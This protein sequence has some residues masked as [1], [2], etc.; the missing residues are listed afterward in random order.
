MDADQLAQATARPIPVDGALER[1][2]DGHPDAA[3]RSL[4]RDCKRDHGAAV[5]QPLSADRRLEVAVPAQPIAPFQGKAGLSA[6]PQAALASPVP[7]HAHATPRA[8]A[9]QEAVDAAAVTLLGL[10][11]SL[12][13][14]G[15]PCQLKVRAR[16]A[17]G[18]RDRGSVPDRGLAKPD[19]AGITS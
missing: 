11:G 13:G 9:A 8:H 5:E 14:F 10:E 3:L 7:D 19:T 17:E 16:H 18:W 2:T 1:A 12:D 6:K 4:A 15:S